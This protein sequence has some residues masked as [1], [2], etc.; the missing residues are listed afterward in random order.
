[1]ADGRWTAL[2]LLA[3]GVFGVG[4][5]VLGLL[6]VGSYS[7][8]HSSHPH[9]H[10]HHYHH[11]NRESHNPQAVLFQSDPRCVLFGFEFYSSWPQV[12]YWLLT[13]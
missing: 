9:H 5:L 6:L 12:F 1:M 11:A 2:W 3:F 4:V 8:S 7:Y 10:H 13:F